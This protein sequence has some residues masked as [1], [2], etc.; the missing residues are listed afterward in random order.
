M[1]K[2]EPITL[3]RGECKV[4]AEA[5]ANHNNSVDRAIEMA[6]RAADAGAWAIKYQ[7]YKASTIAVKQ[8]PKYW[9]DEIGT[10]T[11]YEAFTLSDKLEYR[12]Y[13]DIAQACE[14]LGIEFFATPFDSDA[15]AA[16]E[17]IGARLYKVASADLT[18]RPLLREIGATGKMVMIS[19]GAAELDEIKR[20]L[21]WLDLPA[22]RVVPMACTLT[23]PTPDPDGNFARITGLQKNFPNH[24]IGMSDHTLGVA[25]GW[26]AGALGAVVIEKHYTIDKKLPDV[27]DHAMSVDPE[28]L[29]ELVDAA[30]R[31][32]LLRGSEELSPVASELAAREMARRSVV[33]LEN[34][35]EGHLLAEADLATKRPGTGIGADHFDEVVGRYLARAVSAD[36]PLV[37][38]DLR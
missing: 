14:D 20:A 5:G 3:S 8:S 2:N 17:D 34:L 31:A 16:L 29:R 35:P 12:D 38:D 19:T 6:R 9:S 28:E 30:A 24:M 36:Q 22:D 7:L 25:G 27:P 4:I 32:A 13:G 1:I 21:D 15:V 11:Q 10:A 33:L 37:W 26:M 18:N 23:Y